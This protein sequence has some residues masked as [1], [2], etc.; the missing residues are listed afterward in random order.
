[1][2]K[3]SKK[4]KKKL[5]KL[6]FIS[7]FFT[8]ICINSAFPLPF[9][10]D[11]EASSSLIKVKKSDNSSHFEMELISFAAEEEDLL[12]S[13]IQKYLIHQERI[14]E[15]QLR[16][17]LRLSAKGSGGIFGSLAGIPYFE[18]GRQAGGKNEIVAWITGSTTAIAISGTGVWSYLNLLKGLD[19]HSPEEKDLMQK[20]KLL[21]PIHAS[22]H[23]LGLA[24][25][26]PT[27][28]IAARFNTYKWLAV[29]SYG[30]EYSLKTNGFLTF[31]T[32]VF[33]QKNKI[34]KPL[35]EE[36]LP[37]LAKNQAEI[38]PSL[39]EMSSLLIKHLSKK[40]IPSLIAMENEERN[41]LISLLHQEGN[42]T[43]ENYLSALLNLPS[44]SSSF[45]ET[46]ETWKGGLPR[47]A[48]VGTL[49]ISA[50]MNVVHN[51]HCAY[52]AWKI[53]YDQPAFIIPMAT[54]SIAPTFVLELQ[55]TIKT[56]HAL[57]DSAFYSMTGVS[58]PSLAQSLYPKLMKT[59]PIA[60]LTIAGVT[61]YVG[62]SMVLDI[63][64]DIFP[65]E[66]SLLFSV[67]GVLG[68]FLFTSYVNYSLVEDLVLSYTRSYGE[69]HKKK[70][71]LLVQ[72]IEKLTHVISLA[73]PEKMEKFLAN[74]NIQ[75]TLSL[76]NKEEATKKTP[77]RKTSRNPFRCGIM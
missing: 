3:K 29:I 9:E 65:H 16:N 13:F 68:P 24:A 7:C 74:P 20:N 37:L 38:N 54:L 61:A 47:T 66:Y 45:Q 64:H 75:A 39:L 57:Y 4:S 76:L 27:A 30:L 11:E 8:F 62:R 56:G 69:E 12:Y 22:S 1:M 34:K 52:A 59:L 28:Y 73:K 60:C 67:G 35:S 23:V 15:S 49:S 18:P 51:F 77:A 44:A 58:S 26:V 63:L 2:N 6:C 33:S 53:L 71:A 36:E 72:D 25:A 17:I 42:L 41:E 31:F 5:I 10:E 70:L 40:T 50:L 32:S 46:P 55:A 14:P 19:P 48:F 21:L 43:V